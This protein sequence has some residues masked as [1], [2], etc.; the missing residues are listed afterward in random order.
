MLT[1][2]ALTSLFQRAL[3]L[4]GNSASP[5]PNPRVAALIVDD[6]AHVTASAH[7]HE[8]GAAHA[9]AAALAVAS[10][11]G[12]AVAKQTMIVTLEPCSHTGKTPPCVEAII[13]AGIS[14]VFYLVQDPSGAG[15]GAQLLR[16][17]GVE[18]F[19]PH[20][21]ADTFESPD[22]AQTLHDAQRLLHPWVTAVG[23]KRP[24]VTVKL[25]TT[26]DGQVAASDGSSRWI[27]S[28]CARI[29]SHQVRAFTDGLA[30]GT[31]T[32]AADNPSLTARD[33]HGP[34]PI[35]Y[36][37]L[38]IVVGKREIPA[39][40]RL[41]GY[42]GEVLHVASHDVHNVL[43]QAYERGVRH[44]VV[45]GGPTLISALFAANLID[46]IHHY[47]APAYLGS[48]HTAIADFGATT[49]DDISRWHRHFFL[50]LS[51]DLLL[52]MTP[53]PDHL[54]SAVPGTWNNSKG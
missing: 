18:V 51:P 38:R 5:C 53:S 7:H 24:F 8:A 40:A 12:S 9:E 15:G 6:E 1:S 29:H 32:V 34:L 41:R 36:Q 39:D 45:E 35:A 49:M 3:K 11:Q 10:E 17:A 28:S 19:G 21:I 44:L 20:E 47:L 42:G 33:E 2:S 37:P 27:T 14:R 23:R 43:D 31:G 13:A 22:I 50:D 16:A 52:V 30:V 46:E 48:G 4:A 25:A 26:A 54:P